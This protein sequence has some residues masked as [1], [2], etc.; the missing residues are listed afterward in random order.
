MPEDSF[1]SDMPEIAAQAEANALVTGG[2][3]F[4]GSRLCDLLRAAGWN[5]HSVSR[6]ATGAASAHRHWQ[7]D[8]TDAAATRQVVMSTRPDYVFH[9]AGHVWATS[10]LALVLPTFHSNLHT[11]VNLLHALV[12]TKC[13]RFIL[14]GSQ[15]EPDVRDEEAVPSVPYAASKWASSDY[16]RMFH[17]LYQ[18]PGAIARVFMVYGPQQN[19][20]KLIPYVIG[21]L[22][23]GEPPLITSGRRLGDWIYV[24]DVALGLARMSLTPE[25]AG[26]TVD[27][28][29]GSLVSTAELV[30]T[31]CEIA[32]AEVRPVFG[33]LPD[34][35]KEPERAARIDDTRRL[36]GWSPSVTLAE[37]LHRT[38][39]WCRASAA[40][41]AARQTA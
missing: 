32:G 17:Q 29:S 19:E 36:L 16:L 10:D 11:T 3:G 8:L 35:P 21:C 4:I 13:R 41:W 24:D 5:V 7:A 14:A 6:R 27:L 33:A 15:I 23:R 18:F 40:D 30:E 25:A 1:V 34:R 39:K 2:A 26:H 22:L 37:G 31:V 12:D 28:G 9:L 38:V 20:T